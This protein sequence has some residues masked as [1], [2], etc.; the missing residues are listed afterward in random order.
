MRPSWCE[1]KVCVSPFFTYW[2]EEKL[3]KKGPFFHGSISHESRRRFWHSGARIFLNSQYDKFI[4][5]WKAQNIHYWMY[6]TVV[7]GIKWINLTLIG[8]TLFGLLLVLFWTVKSKSV[9][10]KLLPGK[11]WFVL[12]EKWAVR[13]GLIMVNLLKQKNSVN[14]VKNCLLIQR[15][16]YLT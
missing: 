13:K 1:L 14:P 12:L 2:A 11:H 4:L 16:N 8:N 5:Q 6:S 9:K 15:R 10:H 3:E 7:L